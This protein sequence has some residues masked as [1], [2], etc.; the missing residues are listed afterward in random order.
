MNLTFHTR[1]G[2][3]SDSGP[4]NDILLHSWPNTDLI[5]STPARPPLPRH[6]FTCQSQQYT[7]VNSA[8][9]QSVSKVLWIC[10]VLIMMHLYSAQPWSV[11]HKG[12]TQFHLPPTH[13]SYT[14]FTPQPHGVTALWLVLTAPTYKGMARL[15]WPGWLVLHGSEGN[16]KSLYW[17]FFYPVL[18]Q[19]RLGVHH[20]Q[21]K[22][23]LR[24]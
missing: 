17:H 24:L 8:F 18:A 16:G 23:W 19:L 21:Q 13:E 22:S 6:R 5:P 3:I 12:I 1:W 15:S 11:C 14:T 7:Q 20:P 4:N 9:Y 10:V 2:N